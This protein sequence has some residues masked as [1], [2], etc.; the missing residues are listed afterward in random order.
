ME[1]FDLTLVVTFVRRLVW[2]NVFEVKLVILNYSLDHLMR[3]DNHSVS[4]TVNFAV[5]VRAVTVHVAITDRF[6]MFLKT[7]KN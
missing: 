2:L 3:L 1:H 5:L 4:K 6:D 7:L